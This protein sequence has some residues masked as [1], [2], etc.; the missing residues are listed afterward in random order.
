MNILP[1]SDTKKLLFDL[2]FFF[3]LNTL[4]EFSDVG[5]HTER[6]IFSHLK[7]TGRMIRDTKPDHI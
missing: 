6:L 2:D 1:T 7:Q 5:Q 3:T 4:L